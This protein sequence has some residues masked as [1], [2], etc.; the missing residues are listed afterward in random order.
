[1]TFGILGCRKAMLVRKLNSMHNNPLAAK[2]IDE[3]ND[4]VICSHGLAVQL[5]VMRLSRTKTPVSGALIFV[6]R[7]FV[8]NNHY[9]H[10]ARYHHEE[11]ES[12]AE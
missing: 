6:A 2:K 12:S 8:Y 5:G 3:L 9:Q 4:G 1:M 11:S 10:G 7:A